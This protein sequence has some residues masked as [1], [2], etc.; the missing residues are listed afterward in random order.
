MSASMPLDKT[1]QMRGGAADGR[2]HWV[3]GY[4]SLLWNPGFAFK[5]AVKA[6]LTGAH[7]SLCVYSWVHRGTEQQPGLVLGLDAGGACTGLAFEVAA[8]HWQATLSYLRQ[9]EQ[10][11]FVYAERSFPVTLEIGETVPALTF[12]VDR[13]HRQYAGKLE[14]AQ[15]LQLVQG[16]CGKS[17]ENWEYVVNSASALVELGLSDPLL[18][19]LSQ[20]LRKGLDR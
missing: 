7:R 11:T 17:G 13:D 14:P 5:R 9:R 18:D 1:R 8:E 10:Q 15:M 2:A 16:A 4:G 20:E 3:F 19:W 12:V 6:E